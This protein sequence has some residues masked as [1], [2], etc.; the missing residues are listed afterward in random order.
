MAETAEI[1]FLNDAAVAHLTRRVGA[2]LALTPRVLDAERA[3]GF[4]KGAEE[5]LTDLGE[6]YITDE[7]VGTDQATRQHLEG[8]EVIRRWQ[9]LVA[10]RLLVFGLI[11]RLYDVSY[12][13]RIFALPASQRYL[14]EDRIQQVAS[15][16]QQQA[17]RL[18][19]EY[20]WVESQHCPGI[21][22]ILLRG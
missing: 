13:L 7:L 3:A 22:G 8:E 6:L 17:V 1:S 10:V 15:A 4:V 5:F 19:A 21:G 18:E 12:G 14:P 2:L 16:L 20:R 11:W 9:E